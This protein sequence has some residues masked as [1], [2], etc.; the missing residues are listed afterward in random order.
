MAVVGDNCIDVYLAPASLFAV[1]GN[2]LNVA[3]GL[4]RHGR[5]T[6]YLGEVGDDEYGRRVLQA[7]G[8]VGM[9]VGRVRVVHGRTWVAEIAVGPTGVARVV[10]ED[11]GACSPYSPTGEELDVLAG[12]RHVHMANLAHPEAVVTELRQR[13]VSTSYDYGRGPDWQAGVPPDIVFTSMEG[14]HSIAH[15]TARARAACD[16]G[17]RVAVATLGAGGSVGVAGSE[18]VFQPA[19]AITPL[20]TLGAGDSYIAT[21]LDEYLRGAS[22]KEAMERA[23]DAAT[24]TCL[25]MGAWPQDHS[26]T[27]NGELGP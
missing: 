6:A 4:A 16:A 9:Q 1:G 27:E 21:F 23:C 19:Q 22:V 24:Q 10:R 20:D 7:A 12:F 11:R 2:A 5:A 26:L 15:A 18:V 25:H 17:A 14:D 3:V 13:G 8:S